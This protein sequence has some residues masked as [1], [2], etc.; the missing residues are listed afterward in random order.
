VDIRHKTVE[1][2]AQ[3]E[4]LYQLKSEP[5]IAEATGSLHVYAAGVDLDPRGVRRVMEE[6]S[7][8]RRMSLGRMLDTE[9]TSLVHVARYDTTRCRG[10]RS[11]RT[12]STS[13]Q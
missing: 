8:N 11:V 9:S 2:F 7:L 12:D 5:H 6:R 13:A 3:A 10:P 4:F 1:E